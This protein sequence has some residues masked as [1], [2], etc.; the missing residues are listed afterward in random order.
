[1]LSSSAILASVA[2]GLA[3]PGASLVSTYMDTNAGINWGA[4]A[5]ATVLLAANLMSVFWKQIRGKE[6]GSK[7]KTKS[8]IYSTRLGRGFFTAKKLF[9]SKIGMHGEYFMVKYLACELLE[10]CVQ[11]YS[12]HNANWCIFCVYFMYK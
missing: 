4:L 6:H 8:R 3:V 9:S 12:S 1:M 11:G 5:F 7:P 10:F 2:F